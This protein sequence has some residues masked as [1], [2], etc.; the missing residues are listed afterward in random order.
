MPNLTLEDIQ[1]LE[2]GIGSR[3]VPVSLYDWPARPSIQDC[4]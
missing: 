4:V 1:A 3:M 2:G